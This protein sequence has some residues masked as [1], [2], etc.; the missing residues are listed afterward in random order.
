MKYALLL[1]QCI[2]DYWRN[3]FHGRDLGATI[4]LLVFAGALLLLT[5]MTGIM[6]GLSPTLFVFSMI[7]VTVAWVIVFPAIIYMIDS[8]RLGVPARRSTRELFKR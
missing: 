8:G 3:L 1:P 4:M 6:L 5:V 2:W 7:I